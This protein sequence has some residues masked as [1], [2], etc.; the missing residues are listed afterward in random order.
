MVQEL[1][2]CKRLSWWANTDKRSNAHKKTT[3][4]YGF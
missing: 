3:K 2:K 4:Q 1:R